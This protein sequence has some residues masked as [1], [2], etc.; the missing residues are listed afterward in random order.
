[1]TATARHGGPRAGRGVAP[2]RWAMT[3]AA[4]LGVAGA[5][6]VMGG[7]TDLAFGL[8]SAA[9][10]AMAVVGLRHADT[11]FPAVV[12]ALVVVRWVVS[13]GDP[14]SPVTI[15]IAAAL[16]LYHSVAAL[17]ARLPASA[18]VDRDVALRWATRW[19]VVSAAAGGGWALL[20]ALD[21]RDA[22]SSSLAT[23]AALS[24]VIVGLVAL[25][26]R[27]TTAPPVHDR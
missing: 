14:L 8:Y 18:T 9:V 7:T 22:G 15:V 24:A 6:V 16:A 23:V 17:V 21:R 11:W 27:A 12:I 25:R 1:M 10:T 5:L 4:T 3:T 26:R 20:A 19:A 2:Q 13:D